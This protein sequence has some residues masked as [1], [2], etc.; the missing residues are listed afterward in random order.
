MTQLKKKNFNHEEIQE[1][2]D[3]RVEEKVL[4]SDHAGIDI[5]YQMTRYRTKIDEL[6]LSLSNTKLEPHEKNIL[7]SSIQHKQDILSKL[8]S[9][10]R[11]KLKKLGIRC[12]DG[13]EEMQDPS[14]PGNTQ[15]SAD[16]FDQD[17]ESEAWR[18]CKWEIEKIEDDRQAWNRE[19]CIIVK[20]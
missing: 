7:R 15:S 17:E 10:N 16:F 1:N 12:E 14:N 11:V 9:L 3:R 4:S 19:A 2:I 8:D 13:D 5:P 6:K 20:E 18:K